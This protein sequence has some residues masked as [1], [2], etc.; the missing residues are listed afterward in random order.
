[1][2]ERIT[3]SS[4]D[5]PTNASKNMLNRHTED[6]NFHPLA[7]CY[8]LGKE[9]APKMNKFTIKMGRL[10]TDSRR[11]GSKSTRIHPSAQKAPEFDSLWWRLNFRLWAWWRL[12]S[13]L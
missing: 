5:T 3:N 1:M 13:G 12:N 9:R 4:A 7:Q 8:K 2:C 6:T 10:S 11:K